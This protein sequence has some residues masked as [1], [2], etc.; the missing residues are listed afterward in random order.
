[1]EIIPRNPHRK[2]SRRVSVCKPAV[3]REGK[4]S[5]ITAGRNLKWIGCL[6][7]LSS[8]ISRTTTTIRM[9]F[10]HQGIHVHLQCHIQSL[11]NP[12]RLVR[13]R[14]MKVGSRQGYCVSERI[15]TAAASHS[16]RCH[17]SR[18]E[19]RCLV[20]L[21]SITSLLLNYRSSLKKW[22]KS[23]LMFRN[24]KIQIEITAR[25]IIRVMVKVFLLRCLNQET[26]AGIVVWARIIETVGNLIVI[27][28]I[29]WRIHLSCSRCIEVSGNRS[30]KLSPITPSISIRCISL[31][32]RGSE[33]S[34]IRIYYSKIMLTKLLCILF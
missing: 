11:T 31:S 28:V 25:R 24:S 14:S 22:G 29:S 2:R 1:M 3:Y 12:S 13:I 23:L 6:N 19:A 30:A 32:R 27:W 7:R 26:I 5:W 8:R 18:Q 34:F 15:L 10:N 4:I 17:S 20:Q 16:N 21:D 9:S 33:V